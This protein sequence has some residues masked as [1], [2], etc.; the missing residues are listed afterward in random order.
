M[1][2]VTHT[3]EHTHTRTHSAPRVG[4]F[5]FLLD[6][7]CRAREIRGEKRRGSLRMYERLISRRRDAAKPGNPLKAALIRFD[8]N[9]PVARNSISARE[10]PPTRA[11]LSY[12]G[13]RSS[14]D[15]I[16][17]RRVQGRVVSRGRKHRSSKSKLSRAARDI[18]KIPMAIAI[19][20]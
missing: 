16:G 17:E 12:A 11:T 19:T 5:S 3:R 10:S 4:R 13:D 20:R 7:R 6:S 18:A 2:K 9:E 15:V 14:A 8:L 1:R